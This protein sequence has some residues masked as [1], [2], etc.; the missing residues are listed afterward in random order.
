MTSKSLRICLLL[1]TISIPTGRAWAAGS[2]TIGN[3]TLTVTVADDGSFTIDSAGRNVVSK[4]KLSISPGTATKSSISDPVLGD[5]QQIQINGLG[6]A[7]VRVFDDLPFVLVRLTLTNPREGT[8]VLNRVPVASFGVEL[9][10]PASELRTMGTGG[11]LAPARCPGSYVWLAVADPQTRNGIVAA[12]LTN[13]RASGVLFPKVSGDS[14]RIDA[15]GDYGHLRLTPG[16]STQTET[17][18]I[19]Y[20]DDARLGLESWADAVAKVGNIKLKPHPNGFCT[21][22]SEKH[23]AAADEKSIAEMADF[24]A[25]KLK[26]YGFSFLQIDD[27]WQLGAKIEGTP[28][29]NFSAADPHGPYPSG[30]KATADRIKSLGLTP[31]I[32]FMPFAGTAADPYFADKQ[33]L[34][35]HDTDGGLFNCTWG[36]TPL[37]MT[38]P[39]AR[40][41]LRSIVSRISHEWGY[42]YFKMDGLWTG[43]AARQNYVND[44]Y[45]EDRFGDAVFFDPDK[46]NVEAFRDGMKLVRQAA[47]DD[48]FFLGCNMAQNMR[49]FGASFGL[50]DAMRVGPD[51]GGNWRNWS[52]SPRAGSREYFLNGRIW[53]NDPDPQYL[54]ASIPDKEARTIAS[55]T[56]ISGGLNTAGDW[57]PDLPPQRLAMLRLTMPAHGK[58]ARPVDYFDNDPPRQWIV[59]DDSGVSPHWV[60]GLF[61]WSDEPTSMTIPLERLGL[62]GTS[63]YAAFD[64]WA[65]KL[66]PDITG[67]VN[68]TIPAHGCVVLSIRAAQ[69]H[70]QDISTSRHICQGMVDLT[71]EAWD[72]NSSTLTAKS[73][74]VASDVY[75]LRIALPAGSPGSFTASV[76][77][78]DQSAGVTIDS[79]QSNGLL[80]VTINSPTSR[81]VSWSVSQRP[82]A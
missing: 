27:H 15:R 1:L 77:P 79:A 10:K 32:W 18:A 2:Q 80:R 5:G 41:Y 54:R 7:D 17:L 4:G 59:A 53:Y 52:R 76:S 71:D 70:P 24:A 23:G 38:N 14:V 74:V 16:L 29:K 82:G 64:F 11:L 21:W 67:S 43:L 44:A 22:Y 55:W 25:A 73:D 36:G 20:F 9:G 69:D 6:G 58:I 40:D 37:D 48:V 66:I 34:F 50:F 62:T 47:G 45:K 42:T 61:N 60:L 30:M 35:V 51:N 13:D 3:K 26:P 65:N 49:M 39:K 12:W 33:D 19:G 78:E 68:A 8:L 81:R 75:E 28:R 56:T 31:G 57:L 46:T 72:G 63:H